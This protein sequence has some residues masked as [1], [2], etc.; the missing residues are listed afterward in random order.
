[1]NVISNEANSYVWR[2]WSKD[3]GIELCP[4]DGNERIREYV[5]QE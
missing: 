3:V 2:Q 4:V 5:P 1:M